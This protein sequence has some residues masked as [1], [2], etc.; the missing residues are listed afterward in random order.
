MGRQEISPSP[1]R[2]A[3]LKPV[4]SRSSPEEAGTE[5]RRRASQRSA[6]EKCKK[7]ISQE[8][9]PASKPSTVQEPDQ[10]RVLPESAPENPGTKFRRCASQYPAVQKL[11]NRI[12]NEIAPVSSPVAVQE[13]FEASQA[14]VSVESETGLRRHASQ[15]R[16]AQKCNQWI[17]QMDLRASTCAELPRR[18][19]KVV[20]RQV[21]EPAWDGFPNTP[22]PL[23]EI[24]FDLLQEDSVYSLECYRCRTV[25]R[26]HEEVAFAYEG[27]KNIMFLCRFLTGNPCLGEK[28]ADKFFPWQRNAADPSLDQ[29]RN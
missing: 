1:R 25:L 10:T 12:G 11:Q 14:R 20:P 6:A 28:P 23:G 29:N 9:S 18:E 17:K 13:P 7:W 19:H 15:R 26:V 27:A 24:P 8:I 4:Q 16:A 3:V 22:D 2:S 5:L 21:L